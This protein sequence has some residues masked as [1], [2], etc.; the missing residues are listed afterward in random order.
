LDRSSSVGCVLRAPDG[1]AVRGLRRGSYGGRRRDRVNCEPQVRAVACAASRGAA[2][3][4]QVAVSP[5]QCSGV[6]ARWWAR[7]AR[8]RDAVPVDEPRLG[9]VVELERVALLVQ[10]PM[11]AAAEQNQVAE[12]GRAALCPVLDVMGLDEACPVA[13]RVAARAVA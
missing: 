1:P 13:A 11:V 8:P 6:G 5:A 9:V 3:D 10:E 12:L 2:R 7:Y 4:R